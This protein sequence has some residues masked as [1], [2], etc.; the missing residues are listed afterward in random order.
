MLNTVERAVQVMM[1][2]SLHPKGLSLSEIGQE[3]GSNKQAVFRICQTLREFDFV[4]PDA[5]SGKLRLGSA[6]RRI[7][8]SVQAD[9]DLRQLAAP[10]LEQLRDSTR[11]TACLH[12]LLGS[13][14]V[15]IAQA[16]SLD[17]VRFV[18]ELGRPFGLTG[19]PG[20]VFLAFA[21]ERKR[22]RLRKGTR[23][24]A[25]GRRAI[26]DGEL[27]QVRSRGYAIARD[28][29]VIGV[30]SLSAAV[31]GAQNDALAAVTILGPSARLFGKRL[32]LH[33][34]A[35]CDA[36]ERISSLVAVTTG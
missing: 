14:R 30:S 17:E 20:K 31:R 23:A 26:S 24:P 21:D 34:R 3:I 7:A 10:V 1:T 29:T 35:V 28:E 4:R 25:T 27:Q 2:L 12:V 13:R 9:V 33:A 32:S 11:E 18:A 16:E 22:A 6:V 36:A 15:C 8:D 5:Q 19:A